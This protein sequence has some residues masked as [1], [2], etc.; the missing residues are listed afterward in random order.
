MDFKRTVREYIWL[1]VGLGLMLLAM[2]FNIFFKVQISPRWQSWGDEG[3]N[4]NVIGVSAKKAAAFEAELF[5]KEG[6]EL[7]VVLGD[8]G[9]KLIGK[10]VIDKD[11]FESLYAQ[12]GGM[13]EY[14]KNLLYG[15]EDNEL[16]I[17]E[18]NASFLLNIFWALGLGNKSAVLDEGPMVDER[19]GGAGGFAS[20]GGWT[21][22]VGDSMEHYSKHDFIVLTSEQEALVAKAAQ[23]IFRP[24]CDNSTYFPDCNHGMAMLGF[25]ELMAFQGADEEEM[26]E[27]ALRLN[28]YWFPATYLTIAEYLDKIDKSWDELSPKEIL[29]FDYSS[30]SGFRQI[31]SKVNPVQ[32]KGGA[33]CGV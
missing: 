20:T 7:P 12:R 1:F 32:S 15:E 9:Q 16:I 6:V 31:L 33:G 24:C 30:S 19:Y 11:L 17:T 27:A 25:L 3:A 21:L 23:N 2:V 4:A 26:Y 10:G 5:P 8:L 13:G 29:G 14:E 22:S 28:A 18:Q